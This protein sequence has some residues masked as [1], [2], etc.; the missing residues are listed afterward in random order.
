MPTQNYVLQLLQR[1]FEIA[2]RADTVYAFG[3]LE[4]RLQ[5]SSRGHRVDGAIGVGSGKESL[6]SLRVRSQSRGRKT[7]HWRHFHPLRS[8]Q[9]HL[10]SKQCHCGD[11]TS[12]QQDRAGNP[13]SLPSHVRYTPQTRPD[14]ESEM[15]RVRFNEEVQNIQSVMEGDQ[16]CIRNGRFQFDVMKCRLFDEEDVEQRCSSFQTRRQR[17]RDILRH[18]HAL[19]KAA[20][21]DAKRRKKQKRLDRANA[22]WQPPD[23]DSDTVVVVVDEK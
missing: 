10:P 21:S 13:R 16:F 12:R 19:R 2:W 23:T 18:S 15:K 9:T 11:P 1:N 7:R 20:Y 5:T 4:A 8:R 14:M 3:I 17:N 22:A 6:V